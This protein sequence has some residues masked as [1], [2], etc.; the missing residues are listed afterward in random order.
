MPCHTNRPMFCS[1]V[2]LWVA[3]VLGWCT[4]APAAEISKEFQ[5]K[6]GFLFGFA[7]FTEWPPERFEDPENPFV[8]GVF[9]KNVFG[10]ELEEVAKDRTI[11]GRSIV[12][13]HVQTAEAAR[14]THV[15]FIS[16]A[17]DARVG[18]LIQSLKTASVLTVGES[19]AFARA[20]GIIQFV[21]EGD[22]LRF[23][24]NM[25]LA[26]HAG[27]KIS[28]HLQRLARSIRRQKC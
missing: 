3:L 21:Q 8:I 5:L 9:G 13:K 24:I 18:N 12:I 23:V 20:G 11:K 16:S 10:N 2:I 4:S 28:A 26:K 27:L 17:E 1:S 19:E 22:K 6:V 15:L 25:G 14:T 7:R